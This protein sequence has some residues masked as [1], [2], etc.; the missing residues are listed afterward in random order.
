MSRQKF[1]INISRPKLSSSSSPFL[2]FEVPSV[3][4][5][6]KDDLF[7]SNHLVEAKLR[8]NLDQNSGLNFSESKMPNTFQKEEN[9]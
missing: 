5:T 7:P 9:S 3:P 4:K 6:L 1:T 8:D 2:P